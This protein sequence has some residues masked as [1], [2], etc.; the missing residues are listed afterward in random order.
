MVCGAVLV[1][2]KTHPNA[3]RPFKVP[4]MP[5]TPILGILSCLMLMFSLPWENW[6]RL[7]IWLGL[8]FIIYFSYGRYHSFMAKMSAAEL[9]AYD[10]VPAGAVE[11]K[12]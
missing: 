9:A 11:T 3:P 5:V 12:S 6:M 8:G 7:V 2:R 4:F 10:L 1:M